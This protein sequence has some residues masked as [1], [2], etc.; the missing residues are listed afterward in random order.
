VQAAQVLLQV[1]QLPALR[2]GLPQEAAV[3]LL[4]LLLQQQLVTVSLVLLLA[5]Q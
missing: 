5:Q 4:L 2:L 1:P 3:A